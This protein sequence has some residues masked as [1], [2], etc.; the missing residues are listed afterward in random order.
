MLRGAG[1][2]PDADSLDYRCSHLR[3]GSDYDAELHGSPIDS[4][5][6]DNEACMLAA[7]VARR[8]PA[9][10]DRYL[11]FAC[12]TGRITRLIEPLARTSFGVDVSDGMMQVARARC[13]RTTFVQADVTRDMARIDPVDLITAFRFFGNAQDDLRLEALGALRRL[14]RPGGCLIL[15][16]HRNSKSV[17]NLWLRAVNEPLPDY[18]GRTVDLDHPK[19]CRLLHSTGFRVVETVGI[20]LWIVRAALERPE[21]LHS[22]SARWLEWLSRLPFA[23]RFCPDVIVVAQPDS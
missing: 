21:I 10:I 7:I 17:R 3:N 2:P 8:F 18:R 1:A 9:G 22:S 6:S 11:D 13:V 15:N 4:Y 14:L 12:G 23:F 16:N 20:G 5:L 19:L